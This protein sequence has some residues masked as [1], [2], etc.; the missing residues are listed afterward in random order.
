VVR[1]LEKAGLEVL[2]PPDVHSLCCGMAFASKGFT[3]AGDRKAR[4]LFEALQEAS[5][6]GELPVLMDMSPCTYRMKEMF[7]DRLGVEEPAGFA[8]KHLLPGLRVTG[9]KRSVAVHATCS[10]RKLGVDGTLREVAGLF[11]DEVAAPA[12]VECCGWAGDRG[13]L[14]PE[15]AASALGRLRNSLPEG[16]AEGYSTSRTCEI[17]LTVHGGIPYRSILALIDELTEAKR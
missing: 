12:E 6:G 13:F 17:G 16:C 10:A 11:A 4:E 15:L 3:E 7:G 1:L 2:Y 14:V 8:R 5:R 9:R